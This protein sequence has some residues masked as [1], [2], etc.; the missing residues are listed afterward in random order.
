MKN[1]FE[2]Y[3]SVLSKRNEHRLRKERKIRII[4]RTVP[5]LACF[6]LALALGIGYWKN[7]GTMPIIPSDP[8]IIEVTTEAITSQVTENITTVTT[9]PVTTK[10]S[11]TQKT[12]RVSEK[13]KS[14]S[15]SYSVTEAHTQAMTSNATRPITTKFPTTSATDNIATVPLTVTTQTSSVGGNA[16]FEYTTTSSKGDDMAFVHTTTSNGDDVYVHTTT[17]TV[18]TETVTTTTTDSGDNNVPPQPM[19]EKYP[20][21]F[22]DGDIT[23][24][25]NTYRISSD[26][27][28]DYI[29]TAG[30]RGQ[31]SIYKAEAYEIKN[32][33]KAIAIAIKFEEDEGYYLYRNN[34]T[35]ID[36]IKELISPEE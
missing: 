27:V 19:N 2:M 10:T 16:G 12:T 15:T 20:L 25:R 8:V 26:N 36:T 9:V 23:M 17:H 14:T 1:D 4:K 6:I 24:Y 33:D 5:I 31:L 35:S 28:G 13:T 34:N 29:G 22:L 32:I 30:M 18:T 11:I 7:T 3:Q 21:T